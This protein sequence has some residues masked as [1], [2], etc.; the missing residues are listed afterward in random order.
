MKKSACWACLDQRHS[1]PTRLWVHSPFS[2]TFGRY[3]PTPP[4]LA[5]LRC[6]LPVLCCWNPQA[7]DGEGA[8]GLIWLAGP[9]IHQLQIICVFPWKAI[10]PDL[11]KTFKLHDV[12]IYTEYVRVRPH[13]KSTLLLVKSPFP[14][15]FGRDW[16]TPP[17]LT[18]LRCSLPVMC[19]WNPQA[20]DREGALRVDM[21]SRADN[22]SITNNLCVSLK[23]NCAW[24][25]KNV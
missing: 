8:S 17:V 23:G 25:G 1:E 12:S 15:T 21:A 16:P 10:V 19:C 5:L 11:G 4:G 9:I 14:N 7:W 24:L 6:L 2:N 18:L 22:S 13:Q 3:W 20:W